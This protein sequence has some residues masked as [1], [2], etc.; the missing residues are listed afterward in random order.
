MTHKKPAL[1]RKVLTT[2]GSIFFAGSAS[3]YAQ[4]FIEPIEE[5]E[6][7][8]VLASRFNNPTADTTSSV[9]SITGESLE[10]RQITRVSESLDLIPGV[11][12]V[13]LGST[14]NA[15]LFLTRGL[16]TG[17]AQVVVDGVSISNSSNQLGTFLTA[18]SNAQT[19]RLEFLRGPQSVLYG[20]DA[21]GGVLGYETKIGGE[22][23]I[24]L[25]GEAG[26]FESY[27]TSVSASGSIDKL[28]YGYQ[29]GEEFTNNDPSGSNP[30][31]DYTLQ[32]QTLGLKLHA[33]DDL[34]FKFTYRSADSEFDTIAISPFGTSTSRATVETD[35]LTLN[36][37]FV[38]ND[39]WTTKLIL[40][41]Y[42][43]EFSLNGVFSSAFGNSAFNPGNSFEED[44]INWIN[45]LTLSHTLKAVVGYEYSDSEFSNSDGRDIDFHNNGFYLNSHWTPT[46]PLLVE[47]GVR[48]EDHSQFGSD[49]AWNVGAAYHFASTGTRVS[50]RIA[51]SFRTPRTLDTEAFQ[52]GF[53]NQLA[54][55][56]LETET[57][58][59]YELKI[60]QEI[61]QRHS[62]NA[63]YFHQE[64][65]EA[66]F[67]ERFPNFTTQQ[68]NANGDSTVSGIEIEAQGS[69][70]QDRLNYRA[71]WTIQDREEVIDVPDQLIS[72]DINYNGDTWLVGLSANYVDGASYQNPVNNADPLDDR[73]VTRL[74]GHYEINK[75]VKLHARIENLFN[76]S[77]EISP[78]GDQGPGSERG[79]FAGVTISW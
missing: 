25:F 73:I 3:L 32:T 50:S 34:S 36:T 12:S 26:S 10:N 76:E 45:E 22:N 71:V 7:T 18:A 56:N 72:A 23:K 43:E 60:S 47:A 44:S 53:T 17:F 52:G 61:A 35:L 57:T 1:S 54:N 28:E 77:Y 48:I 33:T 63:T 15:P 29:I 30:L 59:G 70:M 64:V 21:V 69:F 58:L 38:A 75:H 4:S 42:E 24:S 51:E 37:E 68:Q 40:G 6:E 8:T 20:G 74:Y 39:V 46:E 31:E 27:K 5:L 55:P 78:F 67:T 11:Q 66:I 41:R 9:S 14:G 16:P 49:T 2:T 62:I 79:Y 13:P 65:E 19:S